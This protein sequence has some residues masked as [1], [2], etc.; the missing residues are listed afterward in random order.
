[1]FIEYG[2][3][4]CIDVEYAAKPIHRDGRLMHLVQRGRRIR[5]GDPA[6]RGGEGCDLGKPVGQSGENAPF[7]LFEQSLL[8]GAL[9][10]QSPHRLPG[11]E[12]DR[13]EPVKTQGVEQLVVERRL[14]DFLWGKNVLVRYDAVSLEQIGDPA[15]C[16]QITRMPMVSEVPVTELFDFL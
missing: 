6:N 16:A 2:G 14:A 11:K 10:A 1:M 12:F 7:I 15:C 5:Q 8:L 3:R 4:A 9:D 13:G